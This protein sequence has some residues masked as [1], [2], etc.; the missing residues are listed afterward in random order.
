M[1][2]LARPRQLKHYNRRQRKK[3]HLGEFR[4][5]I[6]SI[7]AEA[8]QPLTIDQED[9]LIDAF[10]IECIEPSGMSFGGGFAHGSIFGHDQRSLDET[11]RT[12]V[13]KWL[14]VRTEFARV[15]VGKLTDGWYAS[16]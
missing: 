2:A 6:F 4:Q 7:H 3:Y 16:K 8:A 14:N 13:A 11:H 10:I 5:L 15:H 12:I 1:P 9:A